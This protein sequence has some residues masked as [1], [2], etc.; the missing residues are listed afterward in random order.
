MA[1]F[2]RRVRIT[3][4]VSCQ[5]LLSVEFFFD[6]S[7]SGPEGE[8]PWRDMA[9]D[10]VMGPALAL[11]ATTKQIK[12]VSKLGRLARFMS[13]SRDL[14]DVS[15]VL[16]LVQ[17]PRRPTQ[18]FGAHP[19]YLLYLAST[20]GQP[21]Y[22]YYKQHGNR[23]PPRIQACL[24]AWLSIT[25]SDGPLNHPSGKVF[26]STGLKMSQKKRADE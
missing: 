4:L 20:K 16:Y 17:F 1:D 3:V 11:G 22:L 25:S 21:A 6:R 5:F 7:S 23:R 26:L 13:T 18:L 19:L 14:R 15:S 9:D 12:L 24:L 2:D 8:L 10:L